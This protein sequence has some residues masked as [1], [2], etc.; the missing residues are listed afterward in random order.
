MILKITKQHI[1]K[2]KDIKSKKENPCNFIKLFMKLY[3]IY[4]FIKL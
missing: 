3:K 2:R 4:N 1:F